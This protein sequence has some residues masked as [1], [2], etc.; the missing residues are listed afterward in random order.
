V[1]ERATIL[2]V[3]DEA[4]MRALVRTWLEL[5]GDYEVVAEAVDGREALVVY[6][7]LDAPPTPDVVILDSRMPGPSGIEVAEEMLRR[8]PSQ[9]IVLF[10]AYADD[11]LVDRAADIGVRRVISK[12]DYADLP[13]VIRAVREEHTPDA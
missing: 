4:D 3:D 6:D 13:R 2:I 5:E 1:S 12:S 8:V 7:R 10:T 11:D 9:R